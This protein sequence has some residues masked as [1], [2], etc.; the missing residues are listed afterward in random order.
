MP[1]KKWSSCI[2]NHNRV[3]NQPKI[4]FLAQPDTEVQF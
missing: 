4:S 2:T 1:M 3:F